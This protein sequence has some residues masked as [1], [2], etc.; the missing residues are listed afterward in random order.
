MRSCEAIICGQLVSSPGIARFREA[1][2][3]CHHGPDSKLH[4]TVSR[5]DRQIL[6]RLDKMEVHNTLQ[7]GARV[8]VNLLA[9][10]AWWRTYSGEVNTV[11]TLYLK[12]DRVHVRVFAI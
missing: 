2:E 11:S 12:K 3:V 9:Y 5:S 7:G 6:W 10:G 8:V 1:N 4:V